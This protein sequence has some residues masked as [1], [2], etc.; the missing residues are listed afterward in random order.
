MADDLKINGFLSVG[1]TMMDSDKAHIAGADNQG[2]FKQDTIIGLQVSKQVND[3]T[4][5][6]GQLV[7]RGSDD[8]STEA[9]WAFVTYAA[10]DDLDLRMGRLRVPA[11]YYSDFLEVGYTYNPIRPAEE[12]YRLPFSSMDGVDLT[13]R[14][15][16]GNIDGAVQVYYGRYQGD[17]E[18]SGS[19][20]DA[21]FRNLT[22][23]SL[24]AS[25]GNFGGRLSY[26]QAE[27][28]LQDGTLDG[29]ALEDGI[30]AAIGLATLLGDPSAAEDF[31]IKGHTSQFIAAALTYDNG[32]YSAL[33]EWTAFNHETNLLMDDEAWLVSVAKRMGAFTPHLTYSATKNFYESG[34]EGKIQKQL[35][36]ATEEE[37]ITLGLRYDY[38]SSTALKFEIQHNDEKTYDGAD[39]DSA[40][41]YSVAVDLVF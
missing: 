11:F 7:S 15:S 33:A 6:T 17:F 34:N 27:L 1:A 4:S 9:A 21:D 29:T 8:Y 31:N 10:N 32:D 28:N 12:V 2:G 38:D 20:Y 30:N 5:V 22:G 24:S 13:Q 41:L 16:S 26:N 35:P 36:L 18:N 25:M 23:I 37:S 19:T 3:S 40:M 39:G 14:F